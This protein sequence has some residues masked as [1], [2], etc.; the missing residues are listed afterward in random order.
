MS[1]LSLNLDSPEK[2]EKNYNK[3][4][5]YENTTICEE[6]SKD[7]PDCARSKEIKKYLY[8]TDNYVQFGENEQRGNITKN[9]RSFVENGQ[10]KIRV[11][12]SDS[13][14][15]VDGQW[16]ETGVGYV[17]EDVFTETE[18]KKIVRLPVIIK[19]IN[20]FGIYKLNAQDTFYSGSGDGELEAWKN[21]NYGDA[22]DEAIASQVDGS[23]TTFN[24]WDGYHVNNYYYV[25]RVFLTFDTSTIGEDSVIATAT[26]NLYFRSQS[27][28]RGDDGEKEMTFTDTT[29]ETGALATSNFNDITLNSATEFSPRQAID[30]WSASSTVTYVLDADGQEHIDKTGD[31]GFVLRTEYDL[32]NTIPTELTYAQFVASEYT[33][34]DYDP[35]LEI[36][37]EEEEE[38]TTTPYVASCDPDD[39]DDL[40]IISA[41]SFASTTGVTYTNYRVR[42]IIWLILI[43][44]LLWVFDKL[45][46]AYLIRLNKWTKL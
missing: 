24:L 27:D 12:N 42:F 1:I 2:F 28:Q 10:K 4:L 22:R 41:C 14:I 34:T 32:D 44:P 19:K 23:N 17:S 43:I 45:L 29:F 15:E 21:T 33:G 18:R 3:I 7:T 26:I 35:Y 5:D 25:G 20:P 46:S 31:T 9:T 38:A 11:F 8:I 37:L 39:P 30:D 36:Y 16:F 13:F 40:S 6:R